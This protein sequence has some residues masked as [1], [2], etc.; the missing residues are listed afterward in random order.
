[1]DRATSGNIIDILYS[2]LRQLEDI[3]DVPA[4]LELKRNVLLT[5]AELEITEALLELEE[6]ADVSQRHHETCDDDE[7][8]AA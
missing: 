2:T 3:H 8:R 5:I 4:V 6:M 7:A 1:M